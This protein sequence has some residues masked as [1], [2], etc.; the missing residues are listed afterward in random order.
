MAL[1]IAQHKQLIL[2]RIGD[3]DNLS[4]I[5]ANINLL[6]A[7]REDKATPDYKLQFQYVLVDAID[8][9]LG[10]IWDAKYI[11]VGLQNMPLDDKRIALQKLRDDAMA[12]IEKLEKHARL[13][14]NVPTIGLI[15]RTSPIQPNDK[16]PTS[17]YYPDANARAYRGDP[18]YGRRSGR[19]NRY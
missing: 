7:S 18:Y 4:P 16:D 15:E 8:I 13:F 14:N 1:T 9:W 3:N 11:Q 6:W 12:E 19:Y 2:L 5:A 17:G 10:T